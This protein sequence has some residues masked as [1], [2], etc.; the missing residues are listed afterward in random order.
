MRV[1]GTVVGLD[2]LD[3]RRP[4]HRAEVLGRLLDLLVGVIAFAI[5]IIRFVFA[6]R[7]SALLRRSFR[8]S[9]IVWMKYDTGRPATPAFSG[10][11]L[12]FG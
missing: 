11:P 10:R 4:L 5:V 6:L 1:F 12:P 2:D 7:G 9:F 8:K 3:P